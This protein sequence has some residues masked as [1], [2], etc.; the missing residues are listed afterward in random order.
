MDL[1]RIFLFVFITVDKCV[2]NSKCQK[3]N[4]VQNDLEQ[5]LR[6]VEERLRSIEQPIW[7]IESASKNAW[8]RCTKGGTNCQCDPATKRLSCRN[9]IEYLPPNQVIPRDIIY[10]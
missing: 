8:D 2:D 10:M 1:L 6:S 3:S 7:V 9:M 4:S 5:R